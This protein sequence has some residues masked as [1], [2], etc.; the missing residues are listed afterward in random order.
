M[1]PPQVNK[2]QRQSSALMGPSIGAYIFGRHPCAVGPVILP[3]TARQS[4][5]EPPLS[6]PPDGADERYL[7]SVGMPDAAGQADAVGQADAAGHLQAAGYP[8]S[9]RYQPLELDCLEEGTTENLACLPSDILTKIMDA[10]TAPQLS[11]ARLAC[12]HFA[13]LGKDAGLLPR[14]LQFNSAFQALPADEFQKFLDTADVQRMLG[15]LTTLRLT[16]RALQP[17]HLE[18]LCSHFVARSPLQLRKLDL[19][20]SDLGDVGASIVAKCPALAPLQSLRLSHNGLSSAGIAALGAPGAPF[21]LT[22]LDLSHNGAGPSTAAAVAEGNN[23]C[24]LVVL[25][26]SGCWMG[27]VGAQD[28]A[29]GTTLQGLT[30]LY[31]KGNAIG[32]RGAQSLA[33]G[34]FTRLVNLD[35]AWN[36]VG[37]R[38]AAALF[39]PDALPMLQRLNLSENTLE[40]QGALRIIDAPAPPNLKILDLSFNNLTAAGSSHLLL[41]SLMAT[42]K[43]LNLRGNGSSAAPLRRVAKQLRE[44]SGIKI[45]L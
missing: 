5:A 45:D 9:E 23:F 27:D 18:L 1:I 2:T 37:S 24:H 40:V 33:E 7:H 21:Q 41:S 20:Q 12:H 44:A 35:L 10:L 32:H 4:N 31:L 28:L 15:Q 22:K 42:L 30:K 14:Q 13:H 36:K 16:H 38:G 11:A 26:L 25:K 34:G 29:S 6:C 17:H 19:H 3:R 43:R 39:Y 8:E